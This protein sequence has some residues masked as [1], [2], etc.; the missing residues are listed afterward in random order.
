LHFE[1]PRATHSMEVG[2]FSAACMGV[3]VT[4]VGG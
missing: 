3:A 4:E 2:R 1:A